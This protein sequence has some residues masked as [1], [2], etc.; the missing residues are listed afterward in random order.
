MKITKEGFAVL[1]QDTHVS[2]WVEESGKLCHD[3]N[4]G[5]FILP[6]IK[7]GDWVI[8]GGANI[9]DHT[10]AYAEAVGPSGKVWAFEPQPEV[11]ECLL[12]NVSNHPNVFPMP[13][14]LSVDCDS[15]PFALDPKN[16]GASHIATAGA[17]DHSIA[18]ITIDSLD[19][20]KLDFIKLDLEGWEFYALEGGSKTIARCKPIIVMEVSRHSERYGVKRKAIFEWLKVADYNFRALNPKDA[21]GDD[22][23]DLLCEPI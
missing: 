7:K 17:A 9:G 20:L 23:F 13:L 8:D 6:L 15:M 14:G 3:G 11:Y 22:Q 21:L 18:C 16:R 4:V 2:K 12:F 10:V 5:R 19:L 1:E